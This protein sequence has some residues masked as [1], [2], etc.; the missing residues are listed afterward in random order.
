METV[1]GGKGLQVY[2]VNYKSTMTPPSMTL[3]N[4]NGPDHNCFCDECFIQI[5]LHYPNY[6][7]P[8]KCSVLQGLLLVLSLSRLFPVV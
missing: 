7:L 6:K 3:G 2:V 4:W 1:R 5:A 8:Y